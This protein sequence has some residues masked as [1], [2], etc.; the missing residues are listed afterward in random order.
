MTAYLNGKEHMWEGLAFDL[1]FIPQEILTLK[2]G[3][4]ISN[5]RFQVT[6]GGRDHG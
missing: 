5:I 1:E 3:V 6:K 2:T 4:Q